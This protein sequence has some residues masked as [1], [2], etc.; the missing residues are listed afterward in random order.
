MAGFAVQTGYIQYMQTVKKEKAGLN[1]DWWLVGELD[2]FFLKNTYVGRK[3]GLCF[4]L[5]VSNLIY[6]DKELLRYMYTLDQVSHIF[7]PKYFFLGW[8]RMPQEVNA[9]GKQ[10]QL[11]Y[12]TL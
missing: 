5:H 6:S 2:R 4:F 3:A 1:R 7:Y 10:L 12:Y 8:T 9:L 11:F